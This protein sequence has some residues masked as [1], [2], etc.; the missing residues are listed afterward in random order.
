MNFQSLK[1]FL[2]C[3]VFITAIFNANIFA[4]NSS[5]DAT[6]NPALTK[7]VTS[8]FTGNIVLQADGKIIVLGPTRNPIAFN[9]LLPQTSSRIIKK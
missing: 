6:F 9:R 1:F 4:Q 8:N 2:L 3:I 5:V 7:D